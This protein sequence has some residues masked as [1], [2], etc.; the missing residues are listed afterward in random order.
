[1]DNNI[2][3]IKDFTIPNCCAD[4]PIC[5]DDMYCAITN[6]KMDCVNYDKTRHLDCPLVTKIES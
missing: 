5:Y 2:V 6:I 1:M 4:C 3:I